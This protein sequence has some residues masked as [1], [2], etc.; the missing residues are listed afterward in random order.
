MSS[1]PQQNPKCLPA[2]PLKQTDATTNE[3]NATGESLAGGS[4]RE[5][6]YDCTLSYNAER[7]KVTEPYRVAD[8]DER[9]PSAGW[10]AVYAAIGVDVRGD[11]DV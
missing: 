9:I 5:T 6:S 2:E 4:G 3:E 7:Q 1:E 10:R 11:P 8:R